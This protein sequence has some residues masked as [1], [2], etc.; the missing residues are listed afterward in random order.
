MIKAL[1]IILLIG[2]PALRYAELGSDS[3]VEAVLLPVLCLFSGIALAVWFVLLFYKLGVKQSGLTGH[4][5]G[6]G[7]FGSGDG[8]SGDC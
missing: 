5:D 7:G 1:A 6:V 4:G 3:A 8:G 2:L